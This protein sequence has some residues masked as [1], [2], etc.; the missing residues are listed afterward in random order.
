MLPT[1]D[2]VAEAMGLCLGPLMK[3]SRPLEGYISESVTKIYLEHITG[4]APL[5]AYRVVLV[6]PYV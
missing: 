4:K 3:L 2:I 6:P 5:A 1:L